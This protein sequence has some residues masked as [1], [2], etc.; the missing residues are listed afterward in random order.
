M[1]PEQLKMEIR[2]NTE[3][4][5]SRSSGPGGQNVNKLN[6][7]VTAKLV[8]RALTSLTEGEK[9]TAARKLK[10]RIN[11]KG[12]LVCQVQDERNQSRNRDIALMRIE[13]MVIASLKRRPKRFATAPS[14][15]SKERR[16]ASKKQRSQVKQN[17]GRVN[18]GDY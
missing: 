18:S 17:R 10:N 13:A 11:D 2:R 16:L 14:K 15:N 7:K 1:Q 5:F 4:H 6:T 3:F 9:E 12:E 8:I